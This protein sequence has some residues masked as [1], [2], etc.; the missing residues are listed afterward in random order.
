MIKSIISTIIIF[1][2]ISLSATTWFPKERACPV[3]GKKSVYQEIGSSGS[4]IFSWETKFQY[5]YWPFS[6]I[7]SVYSCQACHFTVF[8]YDF[9]SVPAN[10][11]DSLKIELSKIELKE[12]V[13]YYR[14]PMTDRLAIAEK[15]YRILGKDL[16]FWCMF[17]RVFG[18]YYEL[19]PD[20]ENARLC[21]LKAFDLAKQMLGV[22][23]YKGK[24]KEQYYIMACMKNFTAEKD[25]A[26]YYL[27]KAS[28]L[29]YESATMD[30]Q[31][32]VNFNAYLDDLIT[33]Y[34]EL[35]KGTEPE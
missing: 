10:K 28:P 18:Y 2:G 16:E 17:Y 30:E 5:F 20:P 12:Y 29:K 15:V 33:Q 6:D 35:L 19:L 32:E 9:D 7:N 22:E 34:I 24:E 27:Y 31:Q 23:K 21:R 26:L 14:I 13:T 11:L 4:Y 3:C 1:A 25:S 8:L